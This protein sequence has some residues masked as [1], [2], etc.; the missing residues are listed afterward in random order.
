MNISLAKIAF[1]LVIISSITSFDMLASQFTPSPLPRPRR[2]ANS[3]YLLCDPTGKPERRQ[4]RNPVEFNQQQQEH[5]RK[6]INAAI[7]K[8]NYHFTHNE[9]GCWID[10]ED[11]PVG[12]DTLDIDATGYPTRLHFAF[13]TAGNSPYVVYCDV[14]HLGFEAHRLPDISPDFKERAKKLAAFQ[15]LL[16][17]LMINYQ[18]RSLS[19]DEGHNDEVR[20]FIQERDSLKT[21]FDKIL[22]A[23]YPKD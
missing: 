23:Y 14:L 11:P 2:S 10:S 4:F 17:R 20:A 1:F 9:P 13:H 16:Q 6:F 15:I 5:L 12:L 18:I 8:R 19:A 7:C 22:P 3:A 21:K